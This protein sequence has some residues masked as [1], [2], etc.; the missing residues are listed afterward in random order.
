MIPWKHIH[1]HEG[2]ISPYGRAKVYLPYGI[3][4]VC[5]DKDEMSFRHSRNVH[6]QGLSKEFRDFCREGNIIESRIRKRKPN[7]WLKK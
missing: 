6:R 4:Y 7:K 1:R 3:A 2:M 5:L